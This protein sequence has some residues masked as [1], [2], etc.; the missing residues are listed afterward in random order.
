MVLQTCHTPKLER[1]LDSLCLTVPLAQRHSSSLSKRSSSRLTLAGCHLPPSAVGISR[2]FNACAMALNETRSFAWSARIVEA[3]DLARASAPCLLACPL[4]I[5]PPLPDVS[6]PKRLSTLTTVV[7]CHLPPRAVGIPLR[8]N[9]S[10]RARREMKPAA[11]SSRRVE[12]KARA[13]AS[14]ARLPANAPR[15]RRLRDDV[16]PRDF[17]IGQSWH[18]ASKSTEI[19]TSSVLPYANSRLTFH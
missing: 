4:L 1:S 17:F 12:A 9:S 7:Y 6:S 16:S 8:F 3:S 2:L 11:L 14:A 18:P 15:A 13:R 5:L 10:A 19:E